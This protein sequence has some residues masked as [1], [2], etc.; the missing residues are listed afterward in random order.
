M[1]CVSIGKTSPTTCEI[2]AVFSNIQVVYTQDS[3]LKAEVK[4][5]RGGGCTVRKKAIPAIK[6]K[7]M[8]WSYAVQPG[9]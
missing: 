5:G 1:A 4:G 9:D 8:N 6:D 7:L 2:F 3:L